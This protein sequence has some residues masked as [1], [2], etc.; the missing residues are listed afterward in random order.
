MSTE[1]KALDI[2]SR[3]SKLNAKA[4]RKEMK[5]PGVIYGGKIDGGQPIWIEEG[6]LNDILKKNTKSSVIPAKLDGKRSSVIVKEV[7]RD[8]LTG[9]VQ[10][11]D[12][13]AIAKD[14]VLTFD[15][16]LTFLGEESIL[17]K[18]LLLNS[19]IN[20]LSVKGPANEVPETLEIEV[21]ELGIDDK[22]FAKDIKLPES[23]ELLTDPE[24]LVVSVSH[25]KMEQELESIE[26]DAESTTEETAEVPVVE[27][28]EAKEE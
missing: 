17:H 26:E 12:L 11:I 10:H 21:G 13:Q 15:I 20:T 22:L 16:P 19:N 9:R 4:L 2:Q 28:E 6:H 18:K 7:T 24:E 23:V 8:N 25:S 3:D 5:I 1:V 14:E 27:K